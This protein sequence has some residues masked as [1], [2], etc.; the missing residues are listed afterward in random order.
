MRGTVIQLNKAMSAIFYIKGE[1]GE[2]Y[3][4]HRD[5]LS[6]RKQWSHYVYR[7]AYCTFDVVDENKTYLKAV[8]IVMDDVYD[9]YANERKERAAEARQRHEENVQRK[10][11][12]QRK[13]A[14]KQM[15]ALQKR[16]YYN[17]HLRY[18]LQKRVDGEWKTVKPYVVSKDA[19]DI[20]AEAQKRREKFGT[21]YRAKK[22]LVF[23]A[24]N[25]L[26]VKDFDEKSSKYKNVPSSNT[27]ISQDVVKGQSLSENSASKS[28]A[29]SSVQNYYLN[30]HIKTPSVI[31]EE[32]LA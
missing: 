28:G 17:E 7:D 16:E 9:P 2:L 27:E 21:P 22:C 25:K 5:E 13:E 31:A 6:N 19:N 8:N 30:P 3:F 20:F 24:G 14:K 23:T 4:G 18:I 12:N 15:I 11:E 10:L 29:V 32:V 26:I 1:D